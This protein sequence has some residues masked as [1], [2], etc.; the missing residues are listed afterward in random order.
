M[1]N[2]WRVFKPNAADGRCSFSLSIESDL[3]TLAWY[4]QKTG[5]GDGLSDF[6][7]SS[8]RLLNTATSFAA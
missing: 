6:A 1:T 4:D 5:L 3:D 8:G 7:A 2:S